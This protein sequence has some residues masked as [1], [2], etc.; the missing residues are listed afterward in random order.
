V[1]V[2]ESSGDGL[3]AHPAA[4][5]EGLVTYL[6][7]APG[8]IVPRLAGLA[9]GGTTLVIATGTDEVRIPL[10]AT[11]NYQDAASVDFDRDLRDTIA[12]DWQDPTAGTTGLE[13]I[14]L[15]TGDNRSIPTD[16]ASQHE[17]WG[18]QDRDAFPDVIVGQGTRYT[19][20]GNREDDAHR[21][22]LLATATQSVTAGQTNATALRTF[23][24]ADIDGDTALDL[25]VFGNAVVV[26]LADPLVTNIV[27]FRIDCNPPYR[28][29]G[30]NQCAD[31]DTIHFVGAAVPRADRTSDLVIGN[32][33]SRNLYRVTVHHTDTDDTLDVVPMTFVDPCPG[34][35]CKPIRAV[36]ARDLD[37]DHVIDVLAFDADLNA[38]Y[39]ASRTD[40]TGTM[41]TW[42]QPLTGGADYTSVRISVT[43]AP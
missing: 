18:D 8:T 25:V 15:D 3:I 6:A 34:A 14:K 42:L 7:P 33:V 13:I 20:L 16:A 17:A 4:G 27:Q 1:F 24:W 28:I 22:T 35:I 12:L 19:F 38:Y 11:R 30:G 2:L 39:T 21:R 10:I 5:L 29:A 43:G 41:L 36:I 31:F 23:D 9:D 40:P 26:H 37:G 32:D